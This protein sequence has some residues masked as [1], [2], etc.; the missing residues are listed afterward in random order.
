MTAPQPQGA[1]PEWDG[2]LG[3]SPDYKATPVVTRLVWANLSQG[4]ARDVYPGFPRGTEAAHEKLERLAA[5][6]LQ[7]KTVRLAGI[8]FRSKADI[9]TGVALTASVADDP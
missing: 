7:G 6:G 2:F 3:R 1:R 9:T 4:L 5:I 8:R